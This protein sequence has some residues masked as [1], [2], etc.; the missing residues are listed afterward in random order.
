MKNIRIFF[1]FLSFIGLIFC[2]SSC[3]NKEKRAFDKAVQSCK[4]EQM[5]NFLLQYPNA[6]KM[7]LDSARVILAEW[8]SDSIDYAAIKAI[9]DIIE[10]S[11]AELSYMDRHPQGLYIDSVSLMYQDDEEIAAAIISKQEALEQHL[12]EYRG[13]IKDIVFYYSKEGGREYIILSVPDKEGKGRGVW[14]NIID[15]W[16]EFN[17]ADWFDYAINTEDFEDD[18]IMCKLKNG[19]SFTIEI[20]DDKSLYVTA[21]G[22]LFSFIGE[23]DSNSYKSFF[24]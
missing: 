9:K 5:R 11:G 15:G 21:R 18:D 17:S 24:K 20:Y 22:N 2:F 8:E 13:Q 7:L 4:M 23:K 16:S 3:I 12:D 14:G 10:R 1:L 19:A 6:D